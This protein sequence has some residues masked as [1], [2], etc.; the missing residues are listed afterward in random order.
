MNFDRRSEAREPIQLPVFF[1]GGGL[2]VT[3]D[4]SPSGLFVEL[5]A[6]PRR[7]ARSSSRITLT[8][9]DWP[10]R[11]RAQGQI[12]WVEPRGE[13]YGVGVRILDFDA[14]DGVARMPASTSF[15]NRHQGAHHGREYRFLHQDPASGRRRLQ[16]WGRRISPSRLSRTASDP[17]RRHVERPRRQR[18]EACTR[19][20]T[21]TR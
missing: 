4:I 19:S 20:T 21:A 1:E 2:G 12:V 9:E 11:L 14:G 10:V 5:T 18:E 15:T 7:T 3:G 13:R 16:L 6:G 17:A 8:D